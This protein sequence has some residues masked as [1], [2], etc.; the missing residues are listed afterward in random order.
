MSSREI[1][2]KLETTSVR[3]FHKD[4]LKFV[5]VLVTSDLGVKAT[6]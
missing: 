2:R 5:S 1:E 4:R 6:L 3:E